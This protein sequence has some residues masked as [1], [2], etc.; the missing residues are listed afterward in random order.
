MKKS[1]YPI[2]YQMLLGLLSDVAVELDDDSVLPDVAVEDEEEKLLEYLSVLLD[3]L[4]EEF[5]LSLEDELL[6]LCEDV[7]LELELLG[8]NSSVNG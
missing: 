7:L 8:K 6:E 2:V 3:V 1:I 4:N 5:E